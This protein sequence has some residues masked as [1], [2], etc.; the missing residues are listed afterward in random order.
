MP[1]ATVGRG[2]K[3][4][5]GTRLQ[6]GHL[7]EVAQFWQAQVA[8]FWQALKAEQGVEGMGHPEALCGLLTGCSC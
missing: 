3:K 6:A 4:A 2:E 5:V 1:Q 8:Q 7:R